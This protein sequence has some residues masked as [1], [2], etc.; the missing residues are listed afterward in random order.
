MLKEQIAQAATDVLI[1]KGLE[2]W[3]ISAVA[4]EADCAK[5]LVHYHHVTK[6]E[7][8]GTVADRMAGRQICRD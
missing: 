6:T 4:Q 7:L 2:N 3:T 8:L 5:G 1:R